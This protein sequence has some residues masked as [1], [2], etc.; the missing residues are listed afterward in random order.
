MTARTLAVRHAAAHVIHTEAAVPALLINPDCRAVDLAA[1]AAALVDGVRGAL[2][3][4]ANVTA[5]A[6]AGGWALADTLASQLWLANDLLSE[7]IRHIEPRE[8]G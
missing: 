2:V 1:A 6:E 3:D 8:A 7:L 4:V 5:E